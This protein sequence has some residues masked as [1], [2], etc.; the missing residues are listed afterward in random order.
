MAKAQMYQVNILCQHS[1]W[2]HKHVTE[3]QGASNANNH[4]QEGVSGWAMKTYSMTS[5]S[6]P[7]VHHAMNYDC[8]QTNKQTTRTET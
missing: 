2:C 6:Q 7:T 8:L 4:C 1:H 3:T 5:L